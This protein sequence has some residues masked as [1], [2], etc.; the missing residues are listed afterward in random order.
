[1]CVCMSTQQVS[2]SELICLRVDNTGVSVHSLAGVCR[3]GRLSAATVTSNDIEDIHDI[4][5]DER[6]RGHLT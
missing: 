6:K 2:S 1:M 3:I 4:Y 5:A